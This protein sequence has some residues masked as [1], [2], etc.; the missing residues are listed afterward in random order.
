MHTNLTV[1]CTLLIFLIGLPVTACSYNARREYRKTAN[2]NDITGEKF[3]FPRNGK[4][5]I[6]DRDT[7]IQLSKAPKF[8]VYIHESSCTPCSLEELRHWRPILDR[9][10]S[11]R[12]GGMDIETVFIINPGKNNEAVSRILAEYEFRHPVMFDG[13]RE[14]ERYNLLPENEI[15]NSF[16]L[17]RNDRVRL[18][19]NPLLG[20]GAWQSFKVT[21]ERLN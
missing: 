5:S 13:E 16:V 12:T 19:G 14:F 10:D 11:M 20:K 3:T 17:D 1:I 2:I 9:L 8:V 21:I 6:T 4:W 18:A 15:I 7:V